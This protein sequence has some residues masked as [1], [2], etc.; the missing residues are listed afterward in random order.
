MIFLYYFEA[1]LILCSYTLLLS[2]QED[3]SKSLISRTTCS[4]LGLP[5]DT[6]DSFPVLWQLVLVPRSPD[7]GAAPL[8]ASLHKKCDHR[9]YKCIVYERGFKIYA[10]FM[11][12]FLQVGKPGHF[13]VAVLFPAYLKLLN[14]FPIMGVTGSVIPIPVWTNSH[15][16]TQEFRNTR[17]QLR[18]QTHSVGSQPGTGLVPIACSPISDH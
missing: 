11:K 12:G 2:H 4:A 13:A 5:G 10:F 16:K 18:E 9:R 8:A 7:R 14:S 3:G 17:G 6:L 15:W 1:E